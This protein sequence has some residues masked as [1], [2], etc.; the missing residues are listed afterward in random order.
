MSIFELLRQ[1]LVAS[2]TNQC[3]DFLARNGS[4]PAHS[5]RSNVRYE[6][7]L[8][9]SL[10]KT[11]V[12]SHSNELASYA[13]I[14]VPLQFK[15]SSHVSS[16]FTS[17]L[18]SRPTNSLNSTTS[19][20]T[21]KASVSDTKGFI[22]C[23]DE[24]DSDS[25]VTL[26][27]PIEG[28]LCE[29]SPL[30]DSPRFLT[31]RYLHNE[32][33]VERERMNALPIH[34]AVE[35]VNPLP[36]MSV[37]LQDTQSHVSYNKPRVGT[38]RKA[39][40][41]EEDTTS[42]LRSIAPL[43]L[44]TNSARAYLA[45]A[46]ASFSVPTYIPPSISSSFSYFPAPLLSN[47]PFS[48]SSS[49]SSSSGSSQSYL[50]LSSVLPG[51]FNPTSSTILGSSST[52][53]SSRSTPTNTSS[54]L[55]KPLSTNM[56]HLPTSNTINSTN[57]TRSPPKSGNIASSQ[58]TYS[59]SSSDPFSSSTPPTYIPSSS[60]SYPLSFSSRH[61]MPSASPLTTDCSLSSHPH[62][63]SS[64]LSSSSS[65]S[66]SLDYTLPSQFLRTR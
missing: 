46:S 62:S 63:S 50:P 29:Y 5:C 33:A 15:R 2:E 53:P 14:V 61:Y 8:E 13:Y 41:Q 47:L 18:P 24:F 20:S 44:A 42:P 66:S 4:Q 19:C 1:P 3:V 27:E 9:H 60:S 21:S 31:T 35:L 54:V 51:S 17:L 57:L 22:E 26:V 52:P 59:S 7:Q 37:P 38:I 12:H 30:A 39:H 43:S 6:E 49:S 25:D 58:P 32:F 16:R 11:T 10:H 23:I 40:E 65:S 45:E 55:S 64:S 36:S 48:S 34:H 28:T 56:N